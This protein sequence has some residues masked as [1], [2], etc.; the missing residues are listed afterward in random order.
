MIPTMQLIDQDP[1]LKLS[2]IATD[3]H[4]SD[5]FGKT[6]TEVERWVKNV[7]YAPMNQKDDLPVSRAKALSACMAAISGVLNS[8]KPD[9]LMV[10]GD[11]GEVAAA[12]LSALHLGIPVAHIQGGDVSGN[13]DEIMRHAVTKMSHIHFASTEESAKRIKM[14]GEEEWRI[15]VVGDPH[16]DMIVQKK[17]T[18]GKEVRKL[19]DITSDESFIIVLVHPET[20]EHANSYTNMKTILET[21]AGYNLRTL[22]IYPCSDHGYQG[23]LDAISRFAVGKGFSTHRNIEAVNFWGLMSEASVLIGNSSAGLIETPY[24]NLP[25][26]N[27]GKRQ[28]GRQRWVNVIDCPFDSS[29]IKKAI[30][31]A[32]SKDFRKGL[33]K[34]KNKPF[35]DGNAFKK[36]VDVLK[37]VKIDRRLIEKRMTY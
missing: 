6:I 29:A 25:V 30:D 11:R 21:A 16:I 2:V 22:V 34:H 35:G 14:M 5:K 10:I 28:T 4:L 3:M 8:L 31:K 24:F 26:V 12:V 9:I 13:I 37:T 17:Y 36:M 7:F 20:T 19:Y 18:V 33:E 23:I 27:L 32:L 15:H 1:E